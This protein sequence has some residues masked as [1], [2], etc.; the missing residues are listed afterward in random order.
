MARGISIPAPEKANIS[1]IAGEVFTR[2]AINPISNQRNQVDY[3]GRFNVSE[4]QKALQLYDSSLMPPPQNSPSKT[5]LSD[6]YSNL[7]HAFKKSEAVELASHR[8]YDHKIPLKKGFEPPFGS[9]YGM[10]RIELETL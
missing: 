2:M 8:L 9:L 10:S 5:T 4:I 3:V 1:L 6:E 7:T